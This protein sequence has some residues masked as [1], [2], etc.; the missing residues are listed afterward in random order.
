MKTTTNIYRIVEISG[1]DI[2]LTYDNFCISEDSLKAYLEEIINAKR[3]NGEVV[4]E[5][6]GHKM[7]DSCMLEGEGWKVVTSVY[8]YVNSYDK[9]NRRIGWITY[10]AA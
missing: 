6:K 2:V 1:S 9:S 8:K 5:Y 10:K 7:W 4:E 3:D